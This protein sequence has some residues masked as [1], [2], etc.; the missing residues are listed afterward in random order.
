MQKVK[1][2]SIKWY[3]RLSNNIIGA[4]AVEYA[5]MILFIALAIILTVTALGGKLNELLSFEFPF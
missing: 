4:T 2:I 1:E 5:L 3:T